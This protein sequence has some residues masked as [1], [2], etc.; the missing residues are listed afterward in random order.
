[1]LPYQ[2]GFTLPFSVFRGDFVLIMSHRAY[3]AVTRLVYRRKYKCI[4]RYNKV[5]CMSQLC[6][7]FVQTVSIIRL[8]ARIL[9][10]IY[11][12]ASKVC[13]E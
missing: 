2:C 3:V 11:N 8:N 9:R 7:F 10:H 5:G 6:R 13:H 1:M 12:A 4:L